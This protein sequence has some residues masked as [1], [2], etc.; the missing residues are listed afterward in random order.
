MA[1]SEE[2]ITNT[3][4]FKI[5]YNFINNDITCFKPKVI[6]H[7]IEDELVNTKLSCFEKDFSEWKRVTFLSSSHSQTISTTEKRTD[8]FLSKKLYFV[9]LH[10]QDIYSMAIRIV[11][12]VDGGETST[13]IN[14]VPF[15][16]DIIEKYIY[17][18]LRKWKRSF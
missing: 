13:T 15:N 7:I 5:K 1:S 14:D 12:L 3:L 17:F 18:I 11:A 4:I 8:L 2:I 16:K 10:L 9:T 6:E